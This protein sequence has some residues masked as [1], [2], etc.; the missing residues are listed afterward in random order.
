VVCAAAL[1]LA[2]GLAAGTEKIVGTFGVDNWT[3]TADGYGGYLL[4]YGAE[5]G[6]SPD[7]NSL[8]FHYDMYTTNANGYMDDLSS[9]AS[10]GGNVHTANT[11]KGTAAC[12]V[13][14]DEGGGLTY[15]TFDGANSYVTCAETNGFEQTR[16]YWAIWFRNTVGDGGHLGVS[17][18]RSSNSTIG[19]YRTSAGKV[20]G[21]LGLSGLSN[22]FCTPTNIFDG[23]W[24]QL[25]YAGYDDINRMRLWCDGQLLVDVLHY[26]AGWVNKFG[27]SGG[28]TIGAWLGGV[29][30]NPVSGPSDF[31]PGDIAEWISSTNV[32]EVWDQTNGTM[33]VYDYSKSTYGY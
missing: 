10:V 26:Y 32:A 13:K 23:N 6:W 4:E 31:F 21:K 24:H 28:V 8:V 33:D 7:T 1:A 30:T 22:I 11:Y 2:A 17:S 19:A 12:P 18:Q 5:E 15:A 25:V 27:A 20:A 3:K 14:T 9:E 16:G 29:A